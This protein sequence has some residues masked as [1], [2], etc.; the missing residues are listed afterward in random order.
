[1]DF[2]KN[3]EVIYQDE[4]KGAFYTASQITMHPIVTYYKSDTG[5]VRNSSVVISEDNEHDHYAVQH[6][7]EIVDLELEKKNLEPAN[8]IGK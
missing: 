8:Q 1:M 6:F 7:Q 5:L 4:I 3:R 2:A